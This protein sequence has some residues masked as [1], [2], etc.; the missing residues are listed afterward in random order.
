VAGAVSG[1][2]VDLMLVLVDPVMIKRWSFW[3]E[4][5]NS[6]NS[7]V[8][9]TVKNDRKDNRVIMTSDSNDMFLCFEH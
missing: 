3:Q 9:I 6:K 4:R 7:V 8:T 1:T 2:V 5:D